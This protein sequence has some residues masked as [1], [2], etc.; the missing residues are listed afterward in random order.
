MCQRARKRRKM[1]T[2]RRRRW[3]DC[4]DAVQ[5]NRA[6]SIAHFI[7]LNTVYFF[8]CFAFFLFILLIDKKN[9]FPSCMCK[10]AVITLLTLW[11]QNF[12]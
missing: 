8:F 11:Y 5:I 3:T 12:T 1:K 2:R 7:Q 10:K 6:R 4:A 9:A